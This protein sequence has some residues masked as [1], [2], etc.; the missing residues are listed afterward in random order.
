M[1]I[2]NKGMVDIASPVETEEEV[3][4][5]VPHVGGTNSGCQSQ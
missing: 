2:F 4:I 3:Q 5:N 1:F